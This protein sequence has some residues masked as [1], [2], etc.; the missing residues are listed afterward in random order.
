LDPPT[1]T[2][3]LRRPF[4]PSMRVIGVVAR[5]VASTIVETVGL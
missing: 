4:N 1:S 2:W 5:A 3:S